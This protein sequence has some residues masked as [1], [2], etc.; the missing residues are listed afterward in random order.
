MW[1]D[2]YY[3]G[4]RLALETLLAYNIE[5]TV[6]LEKLMEVSFKKKIDR[7]GIKN[8]ETVNNNQPPKIPFQPHL[9]TVLKIKSKLNFKY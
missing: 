5:D 2:Y 1:N 8:F 4:N 7:I 3:N 9:Q 6:N